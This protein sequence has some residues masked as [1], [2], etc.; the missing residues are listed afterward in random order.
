MKK[1]KRSIKDKRFKKAETWVLKKYD[2]VFKRLAE[3]DKEGR[4]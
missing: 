4:K 1:T 3:R 2:K